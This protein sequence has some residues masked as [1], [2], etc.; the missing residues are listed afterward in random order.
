[1]GQGVSMSNGPP[2]E[3]RVNKR[4][5]GSDLKL[6]SRDALS[7]RDLP[8]PSGS[9]MA[10]P[11]AYKKELR[12][13]YKGSELPSRRITAGSDSSRSEEQVHSPRQPARS[14]RARDARSAVLVGDEVSDANCIHRAVASHDRERDRLSQHE[15]APARVGVKKSTQ[16]PTFWREP[17][18]LIQDD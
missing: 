6:R 12:G 17:V 2:K 16:K 11:R 1:M 15:R 14:E 7:G 4:S 10:C 8:L 9:T 3:Y 5:K 18:G 13:A